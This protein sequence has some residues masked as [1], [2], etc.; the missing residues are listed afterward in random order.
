MNTVI[1]IALG[2]AIG[3]GAKAFMEYREDLEIAE[4]IIT[5]YRHDLDSALPDIRQR[6]DG[7]AVRYSEEVSSLVYGNKLNAI[8]RTHYSPV[9]KEKVE[10][11]LAGYFA[12]HKKLV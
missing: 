8:M 4:K 1:S 3:F 9:V 5:Q 12:Q 2:A 7:D 10:E 11:W 6:V